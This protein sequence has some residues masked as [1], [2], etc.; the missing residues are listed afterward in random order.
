M[1]YL[2]PEHITRE[3]SRFA[4]E[5]IRPAI[6]DDEQFV[7]AQVGSM[8]STLR[9]LSGELQGMPEAVDAQH[10]A[11]REA[12]AAAEDV[13]AEHEATAAREA[14]ADARE[15]VAAAEGRSREVEAAVLEA[16]SDALAA[17]DDCDDEVARAARDPLYDFLD[18]RAESQLRLLGRREGGE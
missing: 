15:Q 11:A 14:V 7:E 16:V 5:E 3:F 2:Q 1:P 18:T 6:D 17:V 9:F 4:I 12:L 13:L 8:A 10:A